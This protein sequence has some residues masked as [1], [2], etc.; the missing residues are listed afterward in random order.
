MSRLSIYETGWIDLVFEDR[1]KEYGAYQLRRDS[2]KTKTVR[3]LISN[4]ERA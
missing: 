1:N 2:S 4:F 3:N